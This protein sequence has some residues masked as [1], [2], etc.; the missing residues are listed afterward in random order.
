[1]DE[2]QSKG[3]YPCC[4]RRDPSQ[5]PTP[6]CAGSGDWG[7]PHAVEPFVSPPCPAHRLA[8]KEDG[9]LGLLGS[10]LGRVCSA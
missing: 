6:S 8:D 10:I 9:L 1:M 7:S 3:E 4:V 5:H 2:L